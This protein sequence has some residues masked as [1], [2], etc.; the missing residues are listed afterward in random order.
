ME[1]L[2][3]EQILEASR[4]AEKEDGWE[5]RFSPARVLVVDDAEENRELVKLVLEDVGLQVEGAENG[6]VAVDRIRS[7]PFDVILMDIQMPVMDGFTATGLLRQD[8]VKTPIIALTANAMKGFERECL[9]AGCTG[10]LSKPIDIAALLQTLADLLGAERALGATRRAADEAATPH[11]GLVASRLADNERFRPTIERFAGRLGSKLSAMEASFRAGELQELAGLAH[12][13]KGAAGTVGFDPFT[14]PAAK[15]EQAARAGRGDEVEPL[16]R[17]LRGLFGRMTLAVVDAQPDPSARRVAGPT[18]PVVSR[19]AGNPRFQATI[20]KF[21][22]R[23]E[24]KLLAIEAS[25]ESE[26][27]EVLAGLAHWLKGAAGTVGFDAF[28]GPAAHLELLA[29]EGKTGEIET[30]IQELRDLAARLEA[31]GSGSEQGP[32]A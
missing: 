14:A 8:G 16:I 17:E 25:W 7:D 31:T 10:Y 23:L 18:G 5:W 26:D 21:A 27:L 30:S 22:S 13:L 1:R 28:T 3:P 32:A 12:W 24:E 2:T 29:R 20:E 9:D 4:K 19:L 15:L 6:Q 11:G